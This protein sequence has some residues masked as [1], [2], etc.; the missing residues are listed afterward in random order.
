MC[1]LIAERNTSFT[2]FSYPSPIISPVQDLSDEKIHTLAHEIGH[3]LS[4]KHKPESI[5]KQALVYLGVRSWY[6]T[7]DYDEDS[8]KSKWGN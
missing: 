2:S 1:L 5:V 4:I 7:K 3:A 8:L 6:D